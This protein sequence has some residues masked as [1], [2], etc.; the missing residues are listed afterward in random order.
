[1]ASRCAASAPPRPSSADLAARAPAR[2]AERVADVVAD[3]RRPVDRVGGGVE[4]A[5]HRVAGR[6]DALARARRA[7]RPRRAPR[8][9]SWRGSPARSARRG[10]GRS[11]RSA[12]SAGRDRDACAPPTRERAF[13]TAR[14]AAAAARCR[15]AGRAAASANAVR[16]DDH[17][18][19]AAKT[20]GATTP[21]AESAVCWKP[22][23]APLRRPA[24]LGGDRE[25]EPVP[26]HRQ[27]GRQRRA[28]GRGSSRR[29]AASTATSP[30][31][32][33]T[34]PP[35]R[36]S[37]RI[38]GAQDVRP[39]PDP[40]PQH[41]RRAPARPR[42]PRPR[43]RPSSRARRAGRGRGSPSSRPGRRGRAH[44]PRQT[45]QSRRSRTVHSMSPGVELVLGP[46]SQ[47]DSARHAPRAARSPPGRESPRAGRAARAARP[48]RSARR[49][50]PPSAGRRAR[51][52]A[53]TA[54]NQRITARPL[55]DC[56]APP[57]DPAD[58]EEDEQR[59]EVRR[60]GSAREAGGSRR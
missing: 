30:S 37:G 25:G 23:A 24:D 35:T 11:G 48:P 46:R 43:R 26:A 60:V 53:A 2:G 56:T 50:A 12:R 49:P 38:A 44:S 6:L 57:H 21:T 42:T 47:H 41:R 13:A 39:A 33:A 52:R 4:P 58:G 55:P 31:V 8:A 34:A 15:R 3:E 29:R 36:R 5:G 45:R 17:D 18:T 40:D 10:R 28:P 20:I 22:I 19:V 1:M 59:E 14:R 51:A 54:S 27:A 32:A 7:C 16:Q 9:R